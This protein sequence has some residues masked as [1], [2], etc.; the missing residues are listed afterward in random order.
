MLCSMVNHPDFPTL[1][2]CFPQQPLLSAQTIV[3]KENFT[4]AENILSPG[5]HACAQGPHRS[6]QVEPTATKPSSHLPAKDEK[7]V[8]C[9]TVP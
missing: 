1:S 3:C 4:T 6:A 9:R 7:D 2:S 5:V 8:L